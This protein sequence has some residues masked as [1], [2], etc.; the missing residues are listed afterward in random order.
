MG[1]FLDRDYGVESFAKW[2]GGQLSTTLEARD[3]RGM[4]FPP[5]EEYAKDQA[6]RF[7]ETQVLDAIDEN[8]PEE[9]FTVPD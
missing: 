2:A 4:D 1:V 8:L 3:Y 6:E 9:T 7:A 5:A